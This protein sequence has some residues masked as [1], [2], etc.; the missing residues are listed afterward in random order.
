MAY[1]IIAGCVVFYA[2]TAT[3]EEDP[4]PSEERSTAV[5]FADAFDGRRQHRWTSGYSSL[6]LATERW[7][8]GAL[9]D[10]RGRVVVKNAAL[11]EEEE[12]GSPLPYSNAD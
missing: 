1:R 6:K 4:S 3:P 8:V 9:A 2:H 5:V 11:K 10:V 7:P 12:G